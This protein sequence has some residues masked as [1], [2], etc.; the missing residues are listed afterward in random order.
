MNKAEDALYYDFCKFA[1]IPN[2]IREK[3]KDDV[4]KTYSY[5]R[6]LLSVALQEFV[7]SIEKE[8]VKPWIALKKKTQLRKSKKHGILH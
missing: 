1:N 3:A 5:Q 2:E 6:Y 8:V 4:K 7:D